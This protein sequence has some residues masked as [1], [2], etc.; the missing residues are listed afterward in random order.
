MPRDAVPGAEVHSI[1]PES[2]PHDSDAVAGL[3]EVLGNNAIWHRAKY[4]ELVESPLGL[5]Q[6]LQAPSFI[7]GRQRPVLLGPRPFSITDYPHW[8]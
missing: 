3:P 5:F 4:D 6:S 2:P 1:N 7:L 8:R